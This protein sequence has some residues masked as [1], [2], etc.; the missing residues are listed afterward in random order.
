MRLFKILQNRFFFFFFN[1]TK[2]LSED[3]KWSNGIIQIFMAPVP[4]FY[5]S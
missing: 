5:S 1:D 3:I 2:Y 4:I